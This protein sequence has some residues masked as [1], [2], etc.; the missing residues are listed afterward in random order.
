MTTP[1]SRYVCF[2]CGFVCSKQIEAIVHKLCKMFWDKVGLFLFSLPISISRV[3]I[4]LDTVTKFIGR[5]CRALEKGFGT[6][7][8]FLNENGVFFVCFL[9]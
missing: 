5:D 6:L 7:L 2:T 8:C 1:Y 9:N 4:L 3:I